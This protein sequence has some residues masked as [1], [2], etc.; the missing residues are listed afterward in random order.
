MQQHV[1]PE[2]VGTEPLV[3]A[4]VVALVVLRAVLLLCQLIELVQ[5]IRVAR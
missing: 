4:Q 2:D 3:A 1:V 5:R